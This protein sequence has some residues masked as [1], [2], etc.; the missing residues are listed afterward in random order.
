MRDKAT[1]FRCN[2]FGSVRQPASKAQLSKDLNKRHFDASHKAGD[3]YGRTAAIDRIQVPPI[4]YPQVPASV[5]VTFGVPGQTSEGGR[6]ALAVRCSMDRLGSN[7][8][9]AGVLVGSRAARGYDE[10]FPGSKHPDNIGGC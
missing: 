5:P 4:R 9:E 7:S 3:P 8:T 2:C 10:R 6:V 1:I